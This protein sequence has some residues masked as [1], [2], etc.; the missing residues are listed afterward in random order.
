MDEE[1]D[2]WVEVL[3][4]DNQ[5]LRNEVEFWREAYDGVRGLTY[6]LRD[7]FYK[8]EEGKLYKQEVERTDD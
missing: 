2:S 7:L 6:H 4:N 5:R 8:T 3:Q 1:R